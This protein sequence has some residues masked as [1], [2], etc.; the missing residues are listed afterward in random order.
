MVGSNKLI[1][2]FIR[3]CE[4]GKKRKGGID[5]EKSKAR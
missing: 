5:D 1:K 3:K 4:I 2:D